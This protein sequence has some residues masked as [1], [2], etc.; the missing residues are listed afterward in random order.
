M[1]G[2][3]RV[4]FKAEFKNQPVVNLFHFRSAAWLPGGGNPFDDTLNVLDAV[5]AAYKTEWLDCMSNLYK[6]NTVEGIGYSDAY[7][8][9]T[10]SPQVR[11][12]NEFGTFV[13]TATN[14]AASCAILSLRCGEQHQI[15]GVGSSKRNRGYLA[16]GPLA[17]VHVDDE[18]HI[19]GTMFDHLDTLAQKLDD[20]L[21]LLVPAITLV[22]IRVHEKWV[23][24]GPVRILTFRTY[25]DVLGYAIRRVASF[26][27]SRQPSA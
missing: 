14:G 24:F 23:G 20:S 19:S 3:F 9:V 2:F 12:I 4:A 17:D 16:V 13:G 27:R 15:N 8:I 1:A 7:T 18:S 22:P 25:S 11:T 21:T 10:P 6:L 5:I 26:R